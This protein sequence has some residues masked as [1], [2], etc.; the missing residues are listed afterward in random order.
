M[1]LK[2]RKWQGAPIILDGQKLYQQ[3][4]YLSLFSG[5]MLSNKV[6][7]FSKIISK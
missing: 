2:G 1:P 6:D 4:K 5:K 7:P 3:A